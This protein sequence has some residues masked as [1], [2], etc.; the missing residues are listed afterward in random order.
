MAYV[1]TPLI[2]LTI[3]NYSNTSLITSHIDNQISSSS[4]TH[5]TPLR[6]A[7]FSVNT[8]DPK[9]AAATMNSCEEMT[10]DEI[11]NGKGKYYPGLIPLV[12]AYL[13]YIRYIALQCSLTSVLFCPLLS[14]PVLSCPVSSCLIMS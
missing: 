3:S 8:D 5:L 9:P 1:T 7:D 14:C 2:F 11:F 4:L 12:Y 10:M 6:N 13:D